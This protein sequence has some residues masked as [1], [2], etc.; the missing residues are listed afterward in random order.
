MERRGFVE[1]NNLSTGASTYH[2][3]MG[4]GTTYTDEYPAH[5]YTAAGA[6]TITLTAFSEDGECSSQVSGDVVSN[7]TSVDEIPVAIATAYPNPTS[8]IVVID[9]GQSQ[10]ESLIVCDPSGR[11]I[12]DIKALGDLRGT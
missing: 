1:I 11:V 3:A 10:T 12:K 2:W 9:L 5:N 6:F 8:G 7:W 4:D